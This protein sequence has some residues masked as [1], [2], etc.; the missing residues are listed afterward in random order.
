[1][2]GIM[3]RKIANPKIN[4]NGIELTDL[5]LKKS[6]D[7]HIYEEIVDEPPQSKE[8]VYLEILDN[9]EATDNSL[10]RKK[11]V[12]FKG[13]Q[14]NSIGNQSTS[15][16]FKCILKKPTSLASMSMLQ[17]SSSGY[18]HG[19][20]VATE[21]C[22]H[23]PSSNSSSGS[24]SFSS[25][26]IYTNNSIGSTNSS[27]NSTHSIVF[28]QMVD[29]FL[30]RFTTLSKVNHKTK[31]AKSKVDKNSI[32]LNSSSASSSSTSSCS[33][34]SSSQLI[35][36]LNLNSLKSTNSFNCQCGQP[37]GSQ[38]TQ[39]KIPDNR[40]S[41]RVS[42]LTLDDLKL[43]QKIIYHHNQNMNRTN[44]ILSSSSVHV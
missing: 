13:P 15:N 18:L 17:I 36:S 34:F 30:N 23:S 33:S 28:N 1:M 12:R 39:A 44:Y 14:S 4:K 40:L 24:S 31:I 5:N 43:R 41:F 27:L 32:K 7:D 9:V 19:E 22:S 25:S 3:G 35:D 10:Y 29:E 8:N 26:Q 38:S 21:C 42:N 2:L 11:C 20:E 16:G 6:S 37:N